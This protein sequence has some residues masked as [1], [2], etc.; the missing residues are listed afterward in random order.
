MPRNLRLLDA[1]VLIH[2]A[3]RELLESFIKQNTVLVSSIPLNSEALYYETPSGDHVPIEAT[4]LKELGVG[5]VS[6]STEELKGVYEQFDNVMGPALDAGEVEGL[7]VLRKDDQSGLIY[8]TA[9]VACIRAIALLELS[10]RSISLEAALETCG[11]RQRDID[12]Q[13]SERKFKRHLQEGFAMRLQGQG[14]RPRKQ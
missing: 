14:L 1:D 6:A 7:A 2:L 4:V 3:E 9:D 5:E 13:Y 8:C 12:W 10:E 11:M